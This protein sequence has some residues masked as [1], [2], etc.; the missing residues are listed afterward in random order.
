MDWR[1]FAVLAAVFI[2]DGISRIGQNEE[3]E[4]KIVVE[5]SQALSPLKPR[6]DGLAFADHEPNRF[7][8]LY[9]SS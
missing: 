1:I 8:I 4:A 3:G 9:C 6:S 7:H 5:D 2:Y